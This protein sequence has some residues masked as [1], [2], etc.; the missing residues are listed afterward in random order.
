MADHQK[1]DYFS[2]RMPKGTLARIEPLLRGR[3]RQS[4][5]LREAV[6]REIERR[7]TLL[8]PGDEDDYD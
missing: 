4:E 3:E 8:P 6:E 2:I 5:F 1:F 7:S